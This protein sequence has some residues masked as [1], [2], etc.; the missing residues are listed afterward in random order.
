MGHY[1]SNLSSG[2]NIIDNGGK[3]KIVYISNR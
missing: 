1:R 3:K 2:L